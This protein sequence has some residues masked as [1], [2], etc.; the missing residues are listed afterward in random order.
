MPLVAAGDVHMHVRARRALQDA[1][2]AVRL[3]RPIAQCGRALFANGERHLRSR[4][5]LA[6]IYPPELL[7]ETLNV[8]D[9]C[10]FS[11]DEL[12]YEYPEEIVPAGETPTTWLRKLAEE[13]FRWRFG[14][15]LSSSEEAGVR[16]EEQ[17]QNAPSPSRGRAGA[18]V[19]SPLARRETARQ[20]T[21]HASRLTPHTRSRAARPGGAVTSPS[22]ER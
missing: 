22:A 9:R 5:R 21:P 15:E 12:R 1:L 16:S 14:A 18:G 10:R 7:I 11:L 20:W 19:L 2:T 3:K 6:R 8:A 13:G 17:T 4:E